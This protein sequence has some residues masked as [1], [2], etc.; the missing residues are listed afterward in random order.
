MVTHP[1]PELAPYD[2]E[3]LL[4]EDPFGWSYVARGESGRRQVVKVLK[5]QA[6]EPRFLDY[7][8]EWIADP[9]RPIP[10]AAEILRYERASD[11]RSTVCVTPFYGWPRKDGGGW[12]TASLK[13]LMRHIPPGKAPDIVAEIARCLD[14]V[15]AGGL[16]HG[17][18]RPSSLYFAS[19][20]ANGRL[21]LGGFGQI[22]MGGLQYLGVGDF[23]FY[24]SPEQL[25][26]GDFTGEA[27]ARWDTYAFGVVAFQLLTGHFPRLDRLHR[28]F[29][30][31]ERALRSS[32][33]IAY[34]ELTPVSEHVLKQLTLE[35]AVEWPTESSGPRESELR[36]VVEACLRYDPEHRAPSMGAVFADL[37]ELLGPAQ[38]LA[39][40]QAK[41]QEQRES[42]TEEAESR[43]APLPGA[44]DPASGESVPASAASETEPD[45]PA[46]AS[47]DPGPQSPEPETEPGPDCED[48]PPV[49]IG[50]ELE[51]HPPEVAARAAA[52]LILDR[53]PVATSRFPVIRPVLKWQIA[54][55]ASMAAMLPLT[56]FTVH[57]HQKLN[58]TEREYSDEAATLSRQAEAWRRMQ[59][60]KAQHAEQ[61]K[62]ELNS[63]EDS[64]SRLVGEARL[65]RQVLR[66]TQEAGD[67]FFRLV[68]ENR[69]TDVP[70]FRLHRA[71]ALVKARE[72]YEGLV[73]VYGDA[74]DFLVSTANAL[75][76]LGRIYREQGEFGKSLASFGEAERRYLALLEDDSTSSVEFVKNLAIAKAA[77][78]DLSL[79][80]AQHSIARHYYTESSRY[81]A[82]ARS[83]APVESLRA[84]IEIHGNS[85]AIAECEFAIGRTDAA[86]DGARSIGTQLL[87][88]Q[89]QEPEN[90]RILGTLA[91]SFSLVGRILEARD[92]GDLAKEAYEQSGNLYAR[93]VKLNAAVDAYRLGLGHALARV[94][95][96]ESD[97]GKLEKSVEVLK[98]VVA[99][100]PYEAEYQRT[101]ADVY[102][103]LSRNQRDGGRAENAAK[104]EHE[105]IGILQPIIRENPEAVPSDVLYSYSQRLS[106]LAELLGDAG[107][108]QGSRAPL[109]EAIVVLERISAKDD[110]LAQYRRALA[111]ARG[112]AGFACLKSGD[113]SEAREHLELAKSEWESYISV[114]PEDADA[115]QA[116]RWTSDQLRALR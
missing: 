112:L 31:N 81:W 107:D 37:K 5:S 53:E 103:V 70:D 54:A 33:A 17:G 24:A 79:L 72:H 80:N 84:G 15:H 93:A 82:E 64:R 41:A 28:Q 78:G 96:Q 18:L 30:E 100:N 49:L 75:F 32:A 85:L 1:F 55:V 51:P 16:F 2:L 6:T 109:Q 45:L 13:G 43:G 108:F 105:A 97:I 77:L 106:H 12:Q 115:E 68:L 102:G 10:G 104:L 110:S 35:K 48:D 4:G 39:P 92:E 14:G 88:L 60:K 8:F 20:E 114:N 29:L 9:S 52:P 113:R 46:E 98:S 111:R 71:A 47:A 27:G 83:L 116:V 67:E 36:R 50:E 44:S 40:S 101:L 22:F 91:R 42:K 86:L 99:N 34:G 7:C 11:E 95:L 19:D 58:E 74:P 62:S 63:V 94:G 89:E 59:S 73:E 38:E 87:S 65:A 56:F 3:A 21:R 57:L 66:R 76:Y 25:A 61:L 90:D 69:D 23:L 26:T